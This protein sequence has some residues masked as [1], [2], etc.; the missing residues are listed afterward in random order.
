MN[1]WQGEG[2]RGAEDGCGG[3]G[4]PDWDVRVGGAFGWG[5]DWGGKVVGGKGEGGKFGAGWRVK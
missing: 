5:W 3:D 4:G 2:A 1:Q